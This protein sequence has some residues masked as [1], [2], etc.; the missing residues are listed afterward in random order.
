MEPSHRKPD[1]FTGPVGRNQHHSVWSQAS[2]NTLLSAGTKT[3]A[4]HCPTPHLQ[5]KHI[6]Y[7]KNITDLLHTNCSH[8]WFSGEAGL[9]VAQNFLYTLTQRA[10]FKIKLNLDAFIPVK[11]PRALFIPC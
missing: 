11:S 1:A 6:K 8:G 4:T 5:K 3:T 10:R 7:N 9:Q 2:C